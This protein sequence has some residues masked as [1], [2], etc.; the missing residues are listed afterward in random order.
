MR[1]IAVLGLIVACQAQPRPP[2]GILRGDLLSWEGTWQDGVLQLRLDSGIDY[3]CR[4]SAATFFERDRARI[5]VGKLRPGDKLHVVSDRTSPN[6]KCFARMVRIVSEH[7]APFQWGS[8]RR[9]TESF[10]PRGS[11]VYAGV[12]VQPEEGAFVLRTRAGERHRILLRR[13]TRFIDNG[14]PAGPE[15]LTA[16]RQIYVRAGFNADEEMEAYQVVSGEILQPLAPA[17]RQP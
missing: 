7:E 12:V 9:A 4:F 10:A 17:P 6:A 11:L 15:I 1:L 14:L 2:L 8:L 5:S 3:E 16:N 13:D